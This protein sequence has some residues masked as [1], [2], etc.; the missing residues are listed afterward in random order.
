M[1]N[2]GSAIT[3]QENIF[4][5]SQVSQSLKM[6]VESCFADIKVRGEISGLKVHTSGHQ[7]FTLK[8]QDSILDGVIWR[9]TSL[10]IKLADGMEIIARGRITTYPQR[11]KYQMVVSQVQIA[12]EG[13][14]LKLLNDL[15]EK[16]KKEGLF[17]KRR[18]IPRFPEVI[19]VITSPTG[20]V[21]KDILHRI[22]QRFPC[23]HVIVN[24][25]LV[26]G[27]QAC[28]QICKAIGDFN[29][30]KENKPEV[31]IIARG[32][33]SLEDLW[34]FNEEKLI[35][36]VY[37]SEIKIISAVGHETD[38]TLIDFAADLRAPTPTAAAEMATPDIVSIKKYLYDLNKR[39]CLFWDNDYRHKFLM[40]SNISDKIK[41]F[42][43]VLENYSQILD[44]QFSR[45]ERN[46][47]FYWTKIEQ[48][49]K[50]INVVF[51]EHI[52]DLMD[53]KVNYSSNNL[54]KSYVGYLEKQSQTLSIQSVILEQ[55][56]YQKTL[57]KGFCII[58]DSDDRI[59]DSR[60][61]F[62][63]NRSKKLNVSFHDGA[64]DL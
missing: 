48:K 26:Q 46:F 20:A 44:D 13:A 32:G 40:L 15:K 51:P 54:E 64:S 49:L 55:N 28:D 53:S 21:I 60:K 14:L 19:G 3:A 7:Y 36:A 6:T 34:T 42:S 24:P 45:I 17:E 2:L 62:I 12:G 9:G 38:T 18:P 58:K 16:L 41:R 5:V 1:I 39:I 52:F 63:D 4:T 11:S 30:L 37:A 47:I 57:Q 27:E 22:N 43:F 29:N 56:S 23:C 33:G 31:I 8:D 25:V 50:G 61:S 10:P 59:I 35:R